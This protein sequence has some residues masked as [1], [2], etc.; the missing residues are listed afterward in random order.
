MKGKPRPEKC[1]HRFSNEVACMYAM[2]TALGSRPS[3][4]QFVIAIVAS[5]VP[6]RSLY[7]IGSPLPRLPETKGRRIVV[8]DDIA[9]PGVHSKGHHIPASTLRSSGARS[10]A[11]LY[12]NPPFLHVLF[13]TSF[14]KTYSCIR[15]C[16]SVET[17]QTNKKV[18]VPA[19]RRIAQMC[20][21]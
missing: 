4:D 6:V 18:I 14:K 12:L 5:H 2:R 7:T 17:K 1:W 11:S 8:T 15:G 16:N 20:G 10:T 3:L 9:S 13:L 21:N 19:E